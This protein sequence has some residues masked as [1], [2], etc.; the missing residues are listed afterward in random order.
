MEENQPQNKALNP[1]VVRLG[2]V[3]LLGLILTW[4]FLTTALGYIWPSSKA[5]FEI[6]GE[7]FKVK[8]ENLNLLKQSKVKMQIFPPMELDSAKNKIGILKD[9]IRDYFRPSIDPYSGRNSIPE[10]CMSESL[11]KSLDQEN[12]DELIEQLSLF[13][14]PN[15]RIGCTNSDAMMAHSLF[16]YCKANKRLYWFMVLLA[17]NNRWLNE[18]LAFC[19]GREK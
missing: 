12:G 10:K 15:F 6:N 16:L 9:S 11:P 14:S 7:N 17:G 3:S 5:D 1:T 19:A 13:A 2:L 18:P 8:S 4:A